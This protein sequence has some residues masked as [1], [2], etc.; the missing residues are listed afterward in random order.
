MPLVRDPDS[1]LYKLVGIF[2]CMCRG[3]LGIALKNKK[4]IDIMF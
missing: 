4:N 3:H 1:Y 2:M